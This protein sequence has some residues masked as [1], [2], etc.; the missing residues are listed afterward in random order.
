[1]QVVPNLKGKT[2]GKFVET[3]IEL[4]STVQ[5]DAYRSYRKPLADKYKHDYKVFDPEDDIL[6][7][8]HIIISNAKS[9]VS[10]TYHGLEGKHL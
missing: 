1:M 10:G 7:W 3:N 5:S 8:L 9:F 2:I 6:H 4:G